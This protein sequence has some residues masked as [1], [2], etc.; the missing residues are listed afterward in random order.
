MLPLTIASPNFQSS[1]RQVD[2]LGR[3]LLLCVGCYLSYS[4]DIVLGIHISIKCGEMKDRSRGMHFSRGM[5]EYIF[6]C[7][8]EEYS[9]GFC[10]HVAHCSLA[11][12]LWPRAADSASF[13]KPPEILPLSPV[14]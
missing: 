4:R 7:D 12:L 10:M 1:F 8:I 2:C 6:S 11:C 5:M 14:S 3:H 13:P 9:F